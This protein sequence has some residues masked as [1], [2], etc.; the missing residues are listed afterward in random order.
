MTSSLP[1][2]KVED[3]APPQTVPSVQPPWWRDWV[4]PVVVVAVIS[5]LVGG[6][7]LLTNL[8]MAAFQ[9]LRADIREVKTEIRD[10]RTE[11]KDVRTEIKDV[12]TE[13]KDV[14]TEL[15]EEIKASEARQRQELRETKA[16]LKVDNQAVVER[17]DRMFERLPAPQAG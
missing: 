11:I 7:T 14:R 9:T 12:R 17:L 15:R 3:Q 13:I 4:K 6:L 16:E 1:K 2:A 5:V 10:V 8:G